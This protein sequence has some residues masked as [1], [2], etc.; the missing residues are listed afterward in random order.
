MAV[1]HRY[2]KSCLPH[3]DCD[4]GDTVTRWNSASGGFRPRGSNTGLFYLPTIV[5]D[6]A[7][8]DCRHLFNLYQSQS[9][10]LWSPIYFEK[11][12]SIW[13]LNLKFCCHSDLK[14]ANRVWHNVVPGH[15]ARGWGAVW[16]SG[17]SDALQG[18][19]AAE[20]VL[21]ADEAINSDGLDINQEAFSLSAE[22]CLTLH[23]SLSLCFK[24]VS[25]CFTMFHV[26]CQDDEEAILRANSTKYGLGASI[27]SENLE[28]AWDIVGPNGWA[29]TVAG[30]AVCR[31]EACCGLLSHSHFRFEY[32]QTTC[33]CG[34]CGCIKLY[35][36]NL[37]IFEFPIWFQHL[38][39]FKVA[40]RPTR[41]PTAWRQG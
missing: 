29:H 16:P 31:V 15:T 28:K 14:C 4:T 25:P 41:S 5:V 21:I 39:F 33:I 23:I 11:L 26:L 19:S 10:Q 34:F 9:L 37:N 24:H 3:Q 18:R 30:W 22:T 17:A 32:I 35:S 38:D 20:T 27:W 6:V 12:I 8:A 13:Y 36:F 2:F 7:E 1:S 40:I